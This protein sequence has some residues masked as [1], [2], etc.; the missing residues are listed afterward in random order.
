[1]FLDV[2]HD[3]HKNEKE[4]EDER[5]VKDK[6]EAKRGDEVPKEEIRGGE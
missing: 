6:E 5:V 1:M 3:H 4:K 2:P